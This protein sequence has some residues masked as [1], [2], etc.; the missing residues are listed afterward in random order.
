MKMMRGRPPCGAVVRILAVGTMAATTLVAPLRA[1]DL[2]SREDCR[3][4]DRNGKE[5]ENCTCLRH[6]SPNA[7]T[8]AMPARPGHV[9]LGITVNG[10]QGAEDDAK[11][12]RVQSVLDGGP[13]DKAG[14]REGDIITRLDGKSLLAPLSGDAERDLDL[15][16]SVPVQ[17]LLAISR[18]LDPD[19]KVPV[20]Y[21]RDG[22]V[23]TTTVET[24]DVADRMGWVVYSDSTLRRRMHEL[25]SRMGHL[26]D[27]LA[28]PLRDSLRALAPRLHEYRFLQ[29]RGGEIR[30]L[31]DSGAA[32]RAFLRGWKPDST[33]S[34]LALRL[35]RFDPADRCPG[36]G[37]AGFGLFSDDCVG[38]VQ[39]VALNP[40]L[41]SYFGTDKG[42]LVSDVREDS[43]IGLQA[44]D[45]ILQI[46]AREATSPDQVRRILR[47]YDSKETITFRILRKGKTMNVSGRRAPD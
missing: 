36:G 7:L 11:G 33:R 28:G 12:A 6:P 8:M 21:L 34:A 39:L 30:I 40:G 23:H 22:T 10:R 13:A 31:G 43:P 4:V 38:G 45:V 16:G 46:G 3:C 26:Q 1:Q 24:A 35:N 47:S 37:D 15:D 29:P 20:T 5:I 32:P 19:E 14:I 41:A 17:R 42:V 27:S 25:Q 44:G 18:E 9:R 2:R